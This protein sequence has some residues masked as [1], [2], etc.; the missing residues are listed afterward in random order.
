MPRGGARPVAHGTRRLDWA[1]RP[2]WYRFA[3][4]SCSALCLLG[5]LRCDPAVQIGAAKPPGATQLEAPD[6]PQVRQSVGGFFACLEVGS[7]FIQSENFAV[8]FVHAVSLR[9]H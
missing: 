1:M 2:G 7:H 3:G 5:N 4:R 6:L 8:C 9:W